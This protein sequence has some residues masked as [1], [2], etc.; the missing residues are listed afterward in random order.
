VVGDVAKERGEDRVVGDVGAVT[1]GLVEADA[2][3]PVEFEV[4]CEVLGVGV[5]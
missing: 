5:P 3:E 2:T 4:G 1:G